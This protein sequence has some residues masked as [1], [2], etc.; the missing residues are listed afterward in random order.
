MSVKLTWLGHS[1]FE[2]DIDGRIALIDPFL[3]GNPLA[4]KTADEVNP[5][6]IIVSHA[7]GDHIGDTVEIA[8]RTGAIVVSN[9]EIG[10]WLSA[11]GVENCVPMNPGGTYHGEFLDVRL[12]IA[13]HSSSF[14][15]G[16][17]G[18]MPNGLVITARGKRI[19]FAGDTDI[20]MDMQLIG[21]MGIDVALLP[22]GG[23][24]TM[25]PND[26]L[27]AVKMIRPRFVIPMHI[28]TFPA[29]AQNPAAWADRVDR[30]TLASPVVLDPGGSYTLE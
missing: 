29:I 27:K 7:H 16:T 12:T 5:E 9:F 3:N 28:N 14:P 4:A 13:I 22:I 8:K 6:V 19:Y 18:G 10:N 20:F 21:E 2:I 11:K 15:D 30:E 23:H 26:A 1:V 25:G 17:Y 24:F